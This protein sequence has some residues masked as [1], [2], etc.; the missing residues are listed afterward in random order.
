MLLIC[1]VI[2]ILSNLKI[3]RIK[4]GNICSMI[5]FPED[6]LRNICGPKLIPFFPCLL[7]LVLLE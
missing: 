3:F 6:L 7:S 1:V 2:N 5:R 4:D